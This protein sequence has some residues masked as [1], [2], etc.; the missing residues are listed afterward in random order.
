MHRLDISEAV[1]L[2]SQQCSNPCPCHFAAAKRVLRYLSG[3]RSLCIHYGGADIAQNLVCYT[4][5]DWAGDKST[6]ASILG[7]IWF[8]AGGPISWSSKSQTCIAVSSTE[9]KYIALTCSVQEGLWLRLSLVH[10]HIPCPPTLSIFTDNEGAR[11]LSENNSSHT[12]AKHI[13][14]HYHFI[15]SHIESHIFKVIHTPGVTNPADMLTKPLPRIK[16][17]ECL[18][19]LGLV[20][21]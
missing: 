10:M 2:L 21:C 20:M 16:F 7:F 19:C 1:L 15:C 5:A 6:C 8:M 11:S 12:R 17:V 18:P 3:T 9:S 13:D 4:D 14:I